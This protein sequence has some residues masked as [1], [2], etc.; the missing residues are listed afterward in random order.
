M[1]ISV[2][3]SRCLLDTLL[4]ARIG[5]TGWVFSVIRHVT[6]F[7]SF[8]GRVIA[9]VISCISALARIVKDRDSR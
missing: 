9:E 8:S 5:Q 6:R 7:L 4:K 3:V 1:Y 2:L